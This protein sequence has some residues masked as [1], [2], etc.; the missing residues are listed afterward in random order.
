MHFLIKYCIIKI[1]HLRSKPTHIWRFKRLFLQYY[2]FTIINPFSEDISSETTTC[3][4]LAKKDKCGRQNIVSCPAQTTKQ[5][6]PL[7]RWNRVLTFFL[8]WSQTFYY[9][10]MIKSV[11]L[12]WVADVGK[13]VCLSDVSKLYK[14]RVVVSSNIRSELYVK[15]WNLFWDFNLKFLIEEFV[16]VML[17]YKPVGIVHCSSRIFDTLN[18]GSNT[19]VSRLDLMVKYTYPTKSQQSIKTS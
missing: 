2:E 7:I 6:C 12:L 11:N 15:N 13:L 18:L 1:D 4:A 9:L 5:L 16:G 17:H 10:V 8:Q 19:D 14:H 3:I